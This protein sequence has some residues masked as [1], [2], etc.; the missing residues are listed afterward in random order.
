MFDDTKLRN[1]YFNGTDKII[2]Y[3]D[4]ELEIVMFF[5]LL[6]CRSY[7]YME[8]PYLNRESLVA[9]NRILE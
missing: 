9:M 5:L 4:I 1:N 6:D 3:L 2:G 8:L 7:F